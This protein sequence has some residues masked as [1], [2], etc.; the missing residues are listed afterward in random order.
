MALAEQLSVDRLRGAARNGLRRPARGIA[1]ARARATAS[2]ARSQ[3]TTAAGA[4]GFATIVAPWLFVVLARATDP[5]VG[6]GLIVADPWSLLAPSWGAW[7]LTG[8]LLV[9]VGALVLWARQRLPAPDFSRTT[10]VA[11]GSLIAFAAW[12]AVSVFLWSTSPSGAWRWTVIA[13]VLIVAAVLG[14]VAGAQPEGRRGIVFGLIATGTLTALIGL[15]D[16]LAFPGDARRVLSPLDPTAT[17]GVIALGTLAA[18]A[19]DQGEHPQRRRWLRAAATV[20][21]AAV[22]LSASRGAVGMLVFGVVLLA[23]RGTPIG[24]PLVQAVGGALPAVATALLGS[25]VAREGSA[26]TTG[27]ALVTLLL[28]GGVSLVAWAA[29]RDTG[30]PAELGRWAGD[31]RVQG[32]AALVVVLAVIAVFASG[33]GGLRGAWDRT[34]GAFEAR[35]MPGQPADSTRLWSGTSD[36]RLWRWQAALDAYQQSGDPVRGLGPGTSAQV[37]RRYRR[38]PTPTLTV[39]SAPVAL[40]TESGAVGLTLALIGLLGL[41]LAA[42]AERR[43][44]PRSDGAILLTIGSVVAVHALFNDDHLQPLLMIPAVA[45]VAAIASRQTIEQQIAPP[46]S[47]EQPPGKRTLATAVGAALAFAIAAGAL[48]PARAQLRAREAEAALQKGGAGGLRDAAL[49][50]SQAS[51]LDPLSFQGP[52]I[53]SQAALALQRWTEARRLALRAVKLA[54]EEASAWRA[55]AYVAL[56]EHDR[57]G[58]RTAARK[59]LELDPAAGSTRDIAV[60]ATLESAPAESSPTAIGTPL[61]AQGG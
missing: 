39:P 22:V 34:S 9:A 35:S 27:R 50:A 7:A 41:S 52:A 3:A 61:T 44:A 51:Q 53:G 57:P 13:L 19:L 12:C 5:K 24:W 2:G 43:R 15:T 28:V 1:R 49:F 54:P 21:I 38:D 46:P 17:G 31:R 60:A 32:G 40:L 45:C 55:V 10:V 58:A 16:L 26:D 56:A 4:V 36:G 23:L 6:R 18:L 25:G 37:L 42:R 48:V 20:G 30:A 29:A 33:D 8:L 11:F 47:P 14:L 59:L